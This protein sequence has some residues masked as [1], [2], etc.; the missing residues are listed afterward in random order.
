[1]TKP[2]QNYLSCALASAVLFAQTATAQVSVQTQ[3]VVDEAK[4]TSVPC[5]AGPPATARCW[6][7]TDSQGAPYLIAMP[8]NWSG[9][10]VV[11]AHG[12]PFLGAPTDERANEDLKRW[13]ITVEQGHAWAGSVFRQGGFAVTTAAQDTERVRGIFVQHIAKPKMTLLHGQSW[14]GM[15]AT[16]AGELF[17]RSWDGILLTSA[18]VGG[19]ASYDFRLDI[20]V[21]YQYFC[22]NHPSPNEEAYSLALGLPKLGAMNAADL[23]QR[24]DDCLGL[25]KPAAQRSAEQ[26]KKLQ[27]IAK[28]LRIPESSVASHINWGTFTLADIVH[29]RTAGKSPFGNEGA[30][31]EGSDDD[32]A[33]NARVLR[34]APDPQAREQFAKDTAHQGQ[35]KVPVL[36]AHGIDDA[37][38][39]VEGNTA[40]RESM[41][42]AATE[43]LLVQ[44]FVKSSQHS[45]WGDAMYPPLFEAL[46]AWVE[47]GDKPSAQS[48]AKRCEQL[49]A[50][51]CLFDPQYL[52]KPLSSRVYPRN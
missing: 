6:R 35:F 1:M 15:V 33:L 11:H 23:T 16:K 32:A 41:R 36:T 22:G 10:L 12:G 46:I 49:T 31:Y 29:K 37:T 38:V 47:R 26:A 17:P 14:G 9:V 44:T 39:F 48:V 24:T 2:L 21:L 27:L 19:P 51:Q 28:I 13:A 3:P 20:R 4:P 50:G 5:P 40:L 8:Q 7:G 43:Q 34:Y 25:R 52:P 42:K 30:R 45:Y 18:V